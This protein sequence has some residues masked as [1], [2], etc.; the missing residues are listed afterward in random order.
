MFPVRYL[1]RADLAQ[2]AETLDVPID[3]VKAVARVES[4]GRSGFLEKTDLPVILFEGHVFHRETGGAHDG[5]HPDISHPKW[6]KAHYRGGR[7]EYDRLR[8]AIGAGGGKPEAA[9]KSAS[10]GMFQ[11]MG[12]NHGRAGYGSVVE[13]VN[14]LAT[15][16]DAQ[17]GAF[18]RFLRADRVM[19]RALRGRDWTGFALRYNGGGQ[20]RN[21]YDEKLAEAVDAAAMRR[22]E[23]E[24]GGALDMERA[25][26]IALQAALNRELDA[27]LD[28]D[29]VIGDRTREAARAFRRREG[30]GGDAPVD[31]DLCERLG[32]DVGAYPGRED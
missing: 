16:E 17:L 25:E 2:A 32:V 1:S 13:M 21:A 11:I 20:A 5:T 22:A 8:R 30:L 26:A 28:V 7:A 12:F 6:T 10:W 3:V 15:G 18:I 4:G 19:I 14:D 29:G 24:E 27:G 31:R 9:L 23:E